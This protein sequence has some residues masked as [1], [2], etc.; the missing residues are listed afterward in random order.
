MIGGKGENSN[1]MVPKRKVWKRRGQT[2]DRGKEELVW[3]EPYSPGDWA[4]VQSE[5]PGLVLGG[6]WIGG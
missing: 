1:K 5:S 2:R 3:N 4:L 6:D